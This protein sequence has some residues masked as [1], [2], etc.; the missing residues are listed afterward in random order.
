MLSVQVKQGVVLQQGLTKSL[1]PLISHTVKTQVERQEGG[2]H[3]QGVSYS[4]GS[5]ASNIVV[6][7][8]QGL[9]FTPGEQLSKGS[10]SFVSDHVVREVKLP[11]GRVVQKVFHQQAALFVLNVALMELQKL[12]E[13]NRD[14]GA[15]AAVDGHQAAVAVAAPAAAVVVVDHHHLSGVSCWRERTRDEGL[16]PRLHVQAQVFH[17]AVDAV[18]QGQTASLGLD[19]PSAD[20]TLVFLFAPLLDTVT[21][22]AVSAAQ[23]DRL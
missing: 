5:R 22:E 8:V 11:Q 6:A 16:S 4:F 2:V 10:G 7:H 21:A 15:Q 23:D 19:V 17:H 20:G 12:K 9:E 3:G 14:H 1:P 18:V 13:Q